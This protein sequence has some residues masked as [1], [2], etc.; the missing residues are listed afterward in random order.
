MARTTPHQPRA[1]RPCAARAHTA[2]TRT[3]RTR[4]AARALAPLLVVLAAAC[5]VDELT[6]EDPPALEIGDSRIIEL[7]Y[8]RFEV[9]NFEQ[10]FTREDLLDLPNDVQERLWLLD[11]DLVG[12]PNAPRLL[13]NALAQI[14]ALDPDG[15]SQAARNMQGLLNMTPDNADLHG[16]SFESIIDLAPVIGIAPQ[17]VLADMLDINVEDTFL[18]T[19]AVSRTILDNVIRT[20]PNAQ[21]RRGPITGDNPEGLYPVPYGTLPVTLADAASDFATLSRRFGPVFR[22]G[23]YHPGFI[24]GDVRA[25]VLDRDFSMTVRANANALPYKGVDLTNASS[26]SV[27]S[28]ASQIENLF[29]FEDPNWLTIRG[30]VDGVPIID[31]MTFQIVEADGFIAGGR[32]PFPLAR[33]DSPVWQLPPWTVERILADAARNALR[34]LNSVVRYFLPDGESSAVELVV[35]DGW[36]TLETAGGL[37]SPPPPQYIWDVL[38]EVAQVRLHDGGIPEGEADVQFTLAGV[39]VGVDA[40]S[41]EQTIREN[42]QADPN[43]LLDVAVGLLDNT[44]GAA[45]FYYYRASPEAPEDL[46]GDWLFFIAPQ[47]IAL[48]DGGL[49]VRPY[50][51]PNPGFFADP[52][53]TTRVSSTVALDGDTTRQKVQ[54]HVGDTLYVQDDDGSVFR[55]DVIGKRT[56]NS[57]QLEVTRVR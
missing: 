14:Q 4:T 10:T 52:G 3:A 13:D 18:T 27:N 19:D 11:L 30:L 2:R 22:D 29:D 48:D 20:H 46:Q 38:L 41:I 31:A 23:V 5:G 43:S 34:D 21:L 54:V 26:A 7:R 42:I 44:V 53:L 15:L 25:Q 37:G 33:G 39:P 1:A 50:A 8:L 6:I 49:P 55:V 32:S 35:E 51:Y 28:T 9:K 16:T 40:A 45:D 57:L 17:A 36:A 47:D 12:G 56:R 24:V